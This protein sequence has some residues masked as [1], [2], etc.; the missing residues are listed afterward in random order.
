M[1]A[2]AKNGLSFASAPDVLNVAEAAGLA[3]CGAPAIYEAIRRGDLYARR[4]GRNL[5]VPKRALA[6]WLGVEEE[7]T[8]D[9]IRTS[10]VGVEAKN[11]D[12]RPPA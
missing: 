10:T 11:S 4:I 12:H 5:R 7:A 2:A 9:I 3:R 6:A 1:T 8:A